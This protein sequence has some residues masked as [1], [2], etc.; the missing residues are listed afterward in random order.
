LKPSKPAQS[1]TAGALRG[2]ELEPFA[3]LIKIMNPKHAWTF[4]LIW[5]TAAGCALSFS[6]EQLEDRS[7]APLYSSLSDL[8][9]VAAL[10]MP[11]GNIAVSARGRVF[12]SFHPEAGPETKIAE[13]ISG[14][15]VP[16][17]NG[18]AQKTGFKTPLALRIDRQD[19]LWILDYASHG[20]GTARLMA[21][22]LE[23]AKLVHSYEFPREIA[24]LGS[25]LNDFQVDGGGQM[26]YIA[27]TSIW[28]QNQ[29]LIVYDI[30]RRRA[31]RRLQQHASVKNGPYSVHIGGRPHT[32]LG[33]F[34]LRFG[35][36]SIALS[37]DGQWL[38]YAPL[39]AGVLYR[40]ETAALK[41]E[42]L[43][44]EALGGRVEKFAD[45]TMS[46]GI[47]TDNSGNIYITDMENSAIHRLAA[48]RKLQ[49]LFKDPR[50]LR[51]PD[52]F[53]F[54]PRGNLYVT[55]SAL[56]NVIMKS[57]ATIKAAGPYF[58]YRFATGNSAISGH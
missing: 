16:Y 43:S 41:N 55:D 47:T 25:M 52:G 6:D 39:N 35:V 20:L 7:T 48:D 44:A 12:I 30:Q 23:S 5:M 27:D 34:K 29:A 8:E 28:A 9:I 37:R 49:T 11:P 13:L 50:K 10:E 17:P 40:V 36:D 31:Y 3:V 58:V 21:F 18:P 1:K 45:I 22:D 32:I 26:I 38:Y 33:L 2:H 53:S 19:R 57:G 14:Q 24:G 46:D 42:N 4:L 51:W 54:G 56:Q 15:A